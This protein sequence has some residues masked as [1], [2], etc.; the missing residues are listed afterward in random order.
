MTDRPSDRELLRRVVANDD[1]MRDGSH[2]EHLLP[3]FDE[4]KAIIAAL[5]ARLAEPEEP[6]LRSLVGAVPDLTGGVES[7]TYLQM[8]R[9]IAELRA[10]L[11][12]LVP[13]ARAVE[14]YAEVRGR[15]DACG[16]RPPCE[17]GEGEGRACAHHWLLDIAESARAVLA[18]L[19]KEKPE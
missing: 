17:P 8:K 15:S 4:R 11:E 5:R 10:D 3:H 7:V 2:I 13:V 14:Y 9:E 12:A 6:T 16:A 1:A 19:E 18:R